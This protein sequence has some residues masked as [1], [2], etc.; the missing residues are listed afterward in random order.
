MSKTTDS[1]K[2]FGKELTGL[3][4]NALKEAAHKT[5]D[6]MIELGDAV[7]AKSTQMVESA[8]IYTHRAS[9]N[10][11][12]QKKYQK[13]GELAYCKGGMDGEMAGVAEEIKRIY[14]ELQSLEIALNAMKEEKHCEKQALPEPESE[15]DDREA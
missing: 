13:L 10:D 9:L 14:E 7:A 6:G 1:V 8:K 5:R 2:T 12:L 15:A 4:G 11:E 3:V